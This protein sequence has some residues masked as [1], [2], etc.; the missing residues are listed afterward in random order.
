MDKILWDFAILGAGV[1]SLNM[2][3]QES[4]SLLTFSHPRNPGVTHSVTHYIHE[5][6]V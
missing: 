6:N 4:I 5:C 2:D 3:N 1:K